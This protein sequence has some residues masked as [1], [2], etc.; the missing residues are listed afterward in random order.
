MKTKVVV[1]IVSLGALVYG[2]EFRASLSG[3]VADPSG[4]GI[5][6]AKID[7][8]SVDTRLVSNVVSAEDGSY[9]VPFLNPGMY[10]VIVEKTG[11]HRVVRE[12][13]NLEVSEKAVVDIQLT[14]GEVSQSINVRADAALVET[15]SADRGLTIENNRV[16]N[17]PLSGRSIYGQAWAAPG[18]AVTTNVQRLRPW[19]TAGNTGIAISGGQ[20]GGNEVLI[21]GVSN[22]Y[23]ASNVAFVPPV[24]GTGEFRVQTTSY[25]AQYGWTTGGVV[26]IVTK[27]GTNQFHG[28]AFEFLQNTDLNANSFD[29]NLHGLPVDWLRVNIFGGAIS[30]PVKKDKLF[31]LFTYENMRFVLPDPF[32]TSVPTPRQRS[33]DFSQTYYAAGMLQ[34]IYDPYS[35]QTGPNGNL[36]RDAFPGNVVPTS[37]INP[38]AAKV[39]SIIPLGNV[40]GDPTSGLNNLISNGSSRKFT[41]FFPEYDGRADYNISEKTQMFV[42]YSRNALSENRSFHYST[43]A[44]TNIAETSTNAP[45]TR[46][47]HSATLQVTHIFSPSLV[48]NL[49]A[50]LLRYLALGGSSI[51][52][53]YNLANLG[54]SPQFVSEAA[55]YFPKFNWANYEGA[56]SN[57]STIDPVAQTN[58]L[59]GSVALVKGHHSIKTGLEFRLQRENRQNAGYTAGNFSFDQGFTGQNPLTIQPSSGNSSASFLLGTPAT[60]YVNVNSRPALQ[61]RLWS[62]YIQDDIS[63]TSKFKLNVGLRWDYLGPLTDRFNALLRGFDMT[64]PSPLQTPGLNLQGGPLYAGVGGSRGIFKSDWNNFG[65]RVGAAYQIS[66]KTVLRGGYGLVYAQTFDDPGPAPGFSQ[67]TQMVTSIQTGV[68]FNTLTNPFPNGILRPVGSS[69]G[70]ATYLGQGFSVPNPERVVPW[71]HQFSFEIQRALPGEIL[72]SAAYIGSRTRDLEVSKGINEIPLSAFAL[73]ATALTQNVSNPLAGL[74]PG[75]SLNGAT[76]PRQ[77]LLRPFPQFASITELDLSQGKSEYDSFQL[78]LY[79]RLSAGLNFSAAYTNSKTIEQVVYANPQDTRLLKEV[80]AW[81]IPQSL[82]LNGVYELPFGKGKPFG[83]SVNP[84]LSRFISGWT[85]S[86]IARI[87]EGMPMSFPTGAAPTGVSPTISNRTLYR[88]FDT[89]TLLAS[90][91]TRGCLQGEQPVWTIQQPFTLRTWPLRLASVRN[92][93]IYN[94]DASLLK[95][96]YIREHFNL[97][98]RADFLNA[99]NTPQ[100]FGGPIT[101]VN[102]PNFGRISGAQVQSNLPRIIQLSMRFEF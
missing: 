5:A 45:L 19:A 89:C 75:T 44:A 39:L 52:Q 76:V 102:N 4:A 3:R 37:R 20:P 66:P 64:S 23:T 62:T 41:D 35:T 51:S 7:V 94:L 71:T 1:L 99:T 86:G 69:L 2:Q 67:Q 18:V 92:P 91:A 82:Q 9:Q 98:I 12:G 78:V 15:E 16:E 46:E 61:Q 43:T 42:R 79:K 29:N 65:P 10:T 74:I 97:I 32:I 21:D 95:N 31:F 57:P 11:F 14:L 48:L 72:V 17:T 80:A 56:G 50:G 85:I 90:G 93:P 47:N 40:A 33:G 100:F 13:V 58:S 88:W 81:D 70:L 55:A 59:Q 63:V 54:F 22:L 27:G 84:L 87:Q 26:N 8:V 28:S 38:I 24:E 53:G 30:G 73:G 68:P 96:N 6:G 101:D 25:D 49:R 36:I 77:Q 83:G 60:G 34:T